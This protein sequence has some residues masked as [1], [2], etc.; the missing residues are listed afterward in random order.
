MTIFERPLPDGRVYPCVVADIRE[1]LASVPQADLDG[2]WAVGLAPG[3]RKIH[4]AYAT[5][6]HPPKP[7]IHIYA[8][9]EPYSFRLTPHTRPH[10]IERWYRHDLSYGLRVERV[11]CRYVAHWDRENLRRYIVE[12]VLLHEIGHHV[13][14]KRFGY[15]PGSASEQYADDYAI[16][17]RR[18]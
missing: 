10:H 9:A 13:F 2:L 14:R 17:H 4:F 16:R 18:H 5:Y 15:H 6:Y 12:H 8:Y 7:V 11:G 1:G 3:R